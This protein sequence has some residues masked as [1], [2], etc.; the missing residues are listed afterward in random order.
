MRV[1]RANLN[2]KLS[3][4]QPFDKSGSS[5]KGADEKFCFVPD[6][7]RNFWKFMYRFDTVKYMIR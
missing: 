1:F 2:E 4:F 5:V 3:I 7:S 6:I